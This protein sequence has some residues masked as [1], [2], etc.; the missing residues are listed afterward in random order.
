MVRNNTYTNP[1]YV[2][3]DISDVD[4]SP[5]VGSNTN[6]ATQIM[7]PD[8]IFDTLTEINNGGG[9]GNITLIDGESFEG[10]WPPQ[11]WTETGYWDKENNEKYDGMYSAT[12][13]GGYGKSGYLTSF[14]CDT[15]DA[16]AIYVDFWYRDG[17]CEAGEL[18]LQ[19]YD[20]SNWDTIYD[21]GST[22]SH[23]QWFHFQHRITENQYLNSNFR[24]RFRAEYKL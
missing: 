24:I 7:A 18:R 17:G 3:N 15:S 5:D 1:D 22:S 9:Q 20:G 21:L 12:F 8:M 14:S 4:S 23:D 13:N 6:F 19:Y 2:D 10:S 16:N 11:S